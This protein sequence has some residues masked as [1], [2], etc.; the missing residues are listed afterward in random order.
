MLGTLGSAEMAQII[1]I[2]KFQEALGSMQKEVAG[3][4]EENR[5]RKVEE[6]DKK[7]NIVSPS[8]E[9]GDCVVV[10]RAQGKGHKL[11]FR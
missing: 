2:D 8:F 5:E 6:H 1:G 10:R 4:V 9:I 3:L 7:K 11:T